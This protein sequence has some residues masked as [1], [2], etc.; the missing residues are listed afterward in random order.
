MPRLVKYKP[1]PGRPRLVEIPEYFDQLGHTITVELVDP[2]TMVSKVLQCV[3][4]SRGTKPGEILGLYDHNTHTIYLDNTLRGADLEQ[5]Y[6]HEK[7][8]CTLMMAGEDELSEDE[9]FVDLLAELEYQA[10]KSK[11][12]RRN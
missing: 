8:H 5:T 2:S 10:E 1:G 4:K 9:G 7:M 12:G 11:H 3:P 6:L